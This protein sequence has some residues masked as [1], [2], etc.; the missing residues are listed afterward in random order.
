M[1]DSSGT[2]IDTHINASGC[3]SVVTLSLTINFT[4][5]TTDGM[6][7]CDSAIW[8]GD[9]TTAAAYVDTPET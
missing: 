8:N 6:V 7:A 5:Y 1:Y 2:Y 9:Y 3:D 4:T